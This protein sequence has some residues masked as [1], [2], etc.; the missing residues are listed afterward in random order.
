[1]DRI[2]LIE[3][4]GRDGAVCQV[5]PVRQWPVRVGRA[6]DCDVVL[7]DPHV[8]PHHLSIGAEDGRL[9]VMVGDTV[10]GL[11][12]GGQHLPAGSAA[13]R[14]A[15]EDW[16]VGRTRLCVRLPGEQLAPEQPLP[17]QGGRLVP[18]ALALAGLFAW[19]AW[20]HYLDTEPGEFLTSFAALLITV[21]ALLAGWSFAWALGSKL[22]QHRFD[23][24]THV[25]IAATGLL[26]SGV[27]GATLGV[28]AFATSWVLLSRVRDA[29]ETLVLAGAVYAHLGAV[30]PQRRKVF[31]WVVGS[32]AVA[33]LVTMSAFQYQRTGRLSSEL[34]LTT[35][36]PP[37][38]RLAP[39][40]P[41]QAFLEEIAAMQA[42]LDAKARESDEDAV[43]EEE[44]EFLD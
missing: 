34:Y 11:R 25:R 8:A 9:H 19:T 5:V 38:L 2:A 24:W 16:M 36:P 35:L 31:A 13:V 10:N 14:P 43:L 15:G 12:C 21:S 17:L 3:V 37:A 44:E 30:L 20:S 22:F 23:Y 7:D 28:L 1:M 40:V 6:L 41:P 32:A 33:G 39:A 42:S 29:A 27:L 26:A 4:F 18:L